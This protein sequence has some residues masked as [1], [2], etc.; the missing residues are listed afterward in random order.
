MP[1]G[2]LHVLQEEVARA[3]Q[4][5]GFPE[6][7]RVVSGYEAGRHRFWLHRCVVAQGVETFVVDSSGIAVHRRHRRATTDGLEVHQRLTMLLR[8]VAG[9]QRV[10]RI[11]RVPRV[12]EEARRQRPRA[13]APATRDRTRVLPRIQGQ[14]ASQGLGLP[15]RGEFQP[16]LPVFS[17]KNGVDHR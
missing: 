6:D 10:W 9:E 11:G 13:F 15:P 2:A 4:R 1:A 5:L 16:Q 8:H 12:Q 3:T 17:A 7:P 14:L